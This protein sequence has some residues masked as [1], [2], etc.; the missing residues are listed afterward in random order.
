MT[1][2][3]GDMAAITGMMTALTTVSGVV[4]RYFVKSEIRLAIDSLRLEL[5]GQR[6]EVLAAANARTA[7]Q[8]SD[9]DLKRDLG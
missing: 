6:A 3:A 5:A 4:V 1:L 7:D 9:K 2:T 8:Q